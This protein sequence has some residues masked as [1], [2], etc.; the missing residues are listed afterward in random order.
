MP[1]LYDNVYSF[2]VMRLLP[3]PALLLTLTSF[4]SKLEII[5]LS[6]WA[7]F[8]LDIQAL[9]VKSF[10]SY[11]SDLLTLKNMSQL[12][13]ILRSVTLLARERGM[14]LQAF[15]VEEL[16]PRFDEQHAWHRL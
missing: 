11:W 1:E 15:E 16:C 3:R 2:L 12:R 8:G 6:H 13:L 10:N 7:F 4:H 14:S 9:K 5:S